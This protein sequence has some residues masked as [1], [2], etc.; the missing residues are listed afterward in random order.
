VGEVATGRVLQKCIPL[1]DL[2]GNV[3]SGMGD[4]L[5]GKDGRDGGNEGLGK[6]DHGEKYEYVGAIFSADIEQNG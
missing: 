1:G 3:V 2:L 6:V 5:R 4:N